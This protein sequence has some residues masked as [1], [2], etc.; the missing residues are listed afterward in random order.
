VCRD[1]TLSVSRNNAQS[2]DGVVN[3][4]H[5]GD[6]GVRG[7]GIFSST[8][9]QALELFISND[10]GL[11]W[12]HLKSIPYSQLCAEMPFADY[13]SESSLKFHKALNSLQHL[14]RSGGAV[15][16]RHDDDSSV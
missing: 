15:L 10:V 13:D 7:R 3:L 11:P 6:K 4:P 1:C 14:E 5:V 2:R 16:A 8:A 12:I 9:A